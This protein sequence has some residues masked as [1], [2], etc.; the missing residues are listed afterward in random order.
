[1]AGFLAAGFFLAGAFFAAGLV[2]MSHLLNN[3]TIRTRTQA[4]V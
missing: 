1:L 4:R 2:A 3:E